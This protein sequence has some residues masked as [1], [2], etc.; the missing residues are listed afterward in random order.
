MCCCCCCCWR[1]TITK[2]GGFDKAGPAQDDDIRQH[3]TRSSCGQATMAMADTSMKTTSIRPGESKVV[4]RC[5]R[6]SN[7]MLFLFISTHILHHVINRYQFFFFAFE[8]G[9]R[10]SRNTFPRAIATFFISSV[11]SRCSSRKRPYSRNVCV[12]ARY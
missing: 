12:S 5:L 9:P 10:R 3:E 6:A 2:F 1:Q 7:P 4:A 8:I 11:K